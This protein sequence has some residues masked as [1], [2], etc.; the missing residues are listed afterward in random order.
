MGDVT[1]I[2]RGAVPG[3]AADV[4]ERLRLEATECMNLV[5]DRHYGG[6]SGPLLEEA[7][8]EIQTLRSKLDVAIKALEA[9][10]GGIPGVH[11]HATDTLIALGALNVRCGNANCDALISAPSSRVAHRS[12][13]TSTASAARTHRSPRSSAA[14]PSASIT[15]FRTGT[16]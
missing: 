8:V 13:S 16:A 7:A 10:R 2:R 1:D 14:R 6:S 11:L 5:S 15:A 3:E 12:R 4:T 9:I